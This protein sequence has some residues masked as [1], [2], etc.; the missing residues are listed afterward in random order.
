MVLHVS[1][2]IQGRRTEQA[3][4]NSVVAEQVL[5]LGSSDGNFYGAA[6]GR[7]RRTAEAS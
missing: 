2:R 3:G 5:N 6:H 4:A 1:K 7:Y